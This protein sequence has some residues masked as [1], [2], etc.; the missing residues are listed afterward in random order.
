MS[1]KSLLLLLAGVA[2]AGILAVPAFGLA[3]YFGMAPDSLPP[4]RGD[5]AVAATGAGLPAP[6][7]LVGLGR[8]ESGRGLVMVA[9]P[10]TGVVAE[11]PVE[12]GDLVRAGDRLV[13]LTDEAEARELDVAAR[14]AA[15]Q[16]AQVSSATAAVG[17][18]RARLALAEI[19]AARTRQLRTTGA[20]TDE[21]ALADDNALTVARQ[22]LAEADAA[23]TG[24]RE[25][26]AEQAAERAVRATRLAERTI[27][28]PM[29]AR[30]L[31]VEVLPGASVSATG[32]VAELAPVG[33][34]VARCEIDELFADAVRVGATGRIRAP[35][36]DTPI[37]T[38]VVRFAAPALS[39]KSLF[40]G[41]SGEPEDRRVR[42]VRLEL[43]D[44]ATVPFNARVECVLDPAPS[45]TAR[46]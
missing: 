22:E 25:R 27:R 39:R 34:R 3:G 21:Q 28:A 1:R 19:T 31:R 4:A 24:A 17:R 16:V 29:A 18:A 15:A 10:V 13:R 33:P 42:E 23:L 26:A 46:R 37:A 5:D 8:I 12:A 6:A 35:G 9:S 14:R 41:V 30:V 36:T 11:V 43:A 44:A 40:A 20:A 45:T 2:G 7:R 32:A 38:G